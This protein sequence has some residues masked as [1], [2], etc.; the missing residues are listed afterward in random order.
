M[1]F[2]WIFRFFLSRFRFQTGGE[3]YTKLKQ[4]QKIIGKKSGPSDSYNNIINIQLE[5]VIHANYRLP[6]INRTIFFSTTKKK[7][8]ETQRNFNYS[9]LF[10]RERKKSAQ[11]CTRHTHEKVEATQ[12]SRRIKV[13]LAINLS[14]RTQFL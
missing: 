13:P 7:F 8:N 4:T 12:H 2:S 11:Y 6:Y 14:T 10:E 5:Q 9:L 3:W 1:N